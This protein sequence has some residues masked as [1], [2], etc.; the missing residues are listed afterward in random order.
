MNDSEQAPIIPEEGEVGFVEYQDFVSKEPFKFVS[1]GNLPE[2]TLRYETYGHLN[3]AKDNAISRPM[4]EPAPVTTA[5]LPSNLAMELPHLIGVSPCTG[6]LAG[7][8]IPPPGLSWRPSDQRTPG[9]AS[10][11]LP[12]P[13]RCV[14][15]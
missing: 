8:L 11:P 12:L 14:G 5:V 15:V 2:L 7:R 3:A 1:G 10:A 9:A 13:D 6:L 4:P